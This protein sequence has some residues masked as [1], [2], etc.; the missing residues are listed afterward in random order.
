KVPLQEGKSTTQPRGLHQTA[1]VR[2]G[3]GNLEPF[4]YVGPARRE[5]AQ[6]GMA[7]GEVET[8]EHG[9][10][11]HV[12]ATLVTSRPIEKGEGLAKTGHGPTI[13]TLRGARE[14]EVRSRQGLLDAIPTGRGQRDGPLGRGDRLRMQA[15]DVV[16]EGKKIRD[17]TQPPW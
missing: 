5:R 9:R 11:I 14:T 1:R 17:A 16:I 6:F 4:L 15:H 7:A 8:G 13:G 3:L 10:Q 2:H 12:P